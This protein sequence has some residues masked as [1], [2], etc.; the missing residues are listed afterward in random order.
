MDT[1]L[2]LRYEKL[3][4]LYKS[5]PKK[6]VYMALYAKYFYPSKY[7]IPGGLDVPIVIKTTIDEAAM[8]L[9]VKDR[10]LRNSF[11]Y[12]TETIEDAFERAMFRLYRY[13]YRTESPMTHVCRDDFKTLPVEESELD[14]FLTTNT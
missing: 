14:I 12:D 10:H 2:L 8:G 9:I 4:D 13:G 5:A 11:D 6:F 7:S 1:K 3:I